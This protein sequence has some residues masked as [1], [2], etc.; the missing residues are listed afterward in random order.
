MEARPLLSLG[1]K[2]KEHAYFELRALEDPW[3]STITVR[4]VKLCISVVHPWMTESDFI[5]E[6]LIEWYVEMLE[7]IVAP[8]DIPLT[9]SM[10]VS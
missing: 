4:P 1:I 2:H 10:A 5:H 8:E 3:V 9:R 6:E 7:N